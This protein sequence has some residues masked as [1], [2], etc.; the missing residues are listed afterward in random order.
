MHKCLCSKKERKN[1]S[2]KEIMKE[3][4]YQECGSLQQ[5]VKWQSED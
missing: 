5:D 1:E 3:M 2:E 4:G